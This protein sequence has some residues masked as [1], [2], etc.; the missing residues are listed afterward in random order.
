MFGRTALIILPALAALATSACGSRAVVA[1]TATPAAAATATAKPSGT[2]YHVNVPVAV[3]GKYTADISGT[4][5]SSGKWAFEITHNEILA[6]NPAPG[7]DAFA[8]GVTDITPDHVTFFA[9]PDCTPGNTDKEGVYTY[10]L[11]NNELRFT[12]IDD[13]CLDRQAT[14]TTTP[15]QRQP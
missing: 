14:L 13:L 11:V 9:D 2:P 6:T 1:P 7:A 12:V 5:I 8:L 3:Q 15:W 10:A 4:S